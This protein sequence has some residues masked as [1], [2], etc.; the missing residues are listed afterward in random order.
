MDNS[1]AN[2][3]IFQ[4]NELIWGSDSQK[5]LWKSHIVVFGL[6]GV[7]SFCTEALARSGIGNLTLIDNDVVSASN[8]NRQLIATKDSINKYKTDLFTKRIYSINPEIKVSTH[9]IFYESKYNN[10]IFSTKPDFVI[11]AI[12]SVSSKVD[13]IIY[14]LENNI[15]IISSMGT[16]NRLNPLELFIGDIS[17]T[18]GNG[19]PLSKKLR[20]IL[21]KKGIE[22]GIR[23]V[24]SHEK[25]VKV[26]YDN[27]ISSPSDTK[28]HPPG[29]VV[30][31]PSVAGITLANFV[32]LSI[33]KD[34]V[35]INHL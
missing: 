22:K 11:D 32:V 4:R 21:K 33:I 13:L 9:T 2:E 10:E 15:N 26:D 30:F 28:A 12:D 27:F 1:I 31:V 6:G 29:S 17:D 35:T 20:L 18:I 14:C 19:C 25:P 24:S 3:Q 23:V 8:I 16:G 7:G 5:K 34:N